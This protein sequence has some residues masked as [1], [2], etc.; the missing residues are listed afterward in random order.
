MHNPVRPALAISRRSDVPQSLVDDFLVEVQR[1]DLRI[2]VREQGRGVFAGLEWLMETAIAV[3]VVRPY[4]DSMLSEL[5]KD[6][7]NIL[8][9]AVLKLY[10]K[11]SAMRIARVA[12]TGKVRGDL[13]YS[14]HFQS[15]SSL[16]KTST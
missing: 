3:Y 2:D 9:R 1:D 8:K 14:W 10:E 5:G 4:F 13:V 15:S 7:Y 11:M 12:T 16:V 6:H